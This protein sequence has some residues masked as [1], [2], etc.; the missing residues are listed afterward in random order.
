LVCL[1]NNPPD[2]SKQ[3]KDLTDTTPHSLTTDIHDEYW[4]IV[5]DK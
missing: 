2:H 1:Y 4:R 3:N 5:R